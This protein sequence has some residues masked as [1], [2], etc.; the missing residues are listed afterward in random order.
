[1]AADRVE[2]DARWRAMIAQVVRAG[3]AAGDI[4]DVDVD[5]FVLTFAALLD[6]LSI[7]VALEDP[8]VDPELAYRIA[9]DFAERELTLSP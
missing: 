1:M 6:G 3:Q 5:R 9:M 2:L 7:Q 4:G 8:Q